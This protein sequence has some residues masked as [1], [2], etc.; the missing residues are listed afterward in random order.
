MSEALM[1]SRT[2]SCAKAKER[3]KFKI[4]LHVHR[5]WILLEIGYQ[6]SRVMRLRVLN[7]T[8]SIVT[9]IKHNA[10]SVS[11]GARAK[12]IKKGMQH[13]NKKQTNTCQSSTHLLTSGSQNSLS[14][15]IYRFYTQSKP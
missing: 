6:A 2:E 11:V 12:L 1:A 15:N 9:V 14:S 3:N 13:F 4:F 7:R 5:P 8:L 10:W